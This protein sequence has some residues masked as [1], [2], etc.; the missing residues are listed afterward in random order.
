M[1][2]ER[3]NVFFFFP[4][5][6]R[7]KNDGGFFCPPFCLKKKVNEDSEESWFLLDNYGAGLIWYMKIYYN[8]KYLDYYGAIYQE[9]SL[10]VCSHNLK[11]IFFSGDFSINFSNKPYWYWLEINYTGIPLM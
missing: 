5:C 2:Q 6:W 11:T 7:K 10:I 3:E 9:K 4:F 8:I 1:I